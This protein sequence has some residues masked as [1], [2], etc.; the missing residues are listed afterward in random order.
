MFTLNHIHNILDERIDKIESTVEQLVMHAEGT[1][2]SHMSER[3]AVF[4]WRTTS[5]TQVAALRTS[6]SAAQQDYMRTTVIGGLNALPSLQAAMRWLTRQTQRITAGSAA[7]RDVHEIAMRSKGCCLQCSGSSVD[8]GTAVALLRSAEISEMHESG[9]RVWAMQ[10][11]LTMQHVQKNFHSIL[12]VG[13][14]G[15]SASGVS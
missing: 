13:L 1:P 8:R 12:I 14:D 9:K 5:T 2:R 15:S 4:S 7:H 11:L 10:D 3:S 6:E